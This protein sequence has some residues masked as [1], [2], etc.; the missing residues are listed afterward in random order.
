MSLL[1]VV[2]AASLTLSHGMHALPK[3]GTALMAA[4]T[5]VNLTKKSATESNS[6][7]VGAGESQDLAFVHVPYN[8]GHTIEMIA[9]YG[10]GM[11]AKMSFAPVYLM[12]RNESVYNLP[13]EE[14][15]TMLEEYQ[16][17]TGHGAES[18]GMISPL[19]AGK[20]S[21][22]CPMYL[23]PPKYW[24][25]DVAKSYFGKKKR[26]GLLRDPYER[27]VAIFRGSAGG[28]TGEGYGGNY[29]KYAATCDVDGAVM[30]M[31]K[32]VESN[33]YADGCGLTPQS[34]YF[35]GEYGLEVPVDNR[36]FPMSMNKFFKESGSD[37][38][39]E[40]DDILHVSGC[41]ETWSAALRPETRA[42]V[43]KLY[44]EDFD[45]V[46]KHFG[47]CDV[48]G[49]TCLEYV[50]VMCPLNMTKS[51]PDGVSLPAKS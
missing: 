34:E 41:P 31:L 7:K 10:H 50:P 45:L 24:P 26:F 23:S 8:F 20:S 28:Q 5:S 51:L 27:L 16:P 29:S 49:N 36:L 39:I 14:Q 25:E 38:T 46:C 44:A 32:K 4:M 6:T 33:K 40:T 18:W 48:D 35:E 47:Y 9:A 30:E 12:A 43:R 21:I 13:V 17:P 42:L 1:Y 19:L 2:F 11:P 22:G 3:S 37:F 15:K